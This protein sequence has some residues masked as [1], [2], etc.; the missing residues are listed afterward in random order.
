MSTK[1]EIIQIVQGNLLKQEVIA[2]VNAANTYL[3]GGGGIDG[4]IHH[5]A[6]PQLLKACQFYKKQHNLSH[7]QIGDAV[8][9]ESFDIQK[10]TPTI[11]Y[12][13][14]TVGPNCAISSQNA[15]REQLLTKAYQNSLKVARA[16]SVD[17]IAFPAISTGIYSYP[18]SEAQTVAI[19]A[20]LEYIEKYP[21]HFSDIRLVYYS[22]KDF[23]G[24]QAV[25]NQM[26]G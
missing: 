12:V 17:S 20:I 19:N 23:I 21:N 26:L 25:W 11:H 2:I 16:H 8:L 4:V 14:H 9:T 24:A 13:I 6:G 1:R 18:F 7:I 15:I 10:I 22:N 5:A 3:E